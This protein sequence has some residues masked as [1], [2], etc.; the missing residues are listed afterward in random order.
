MT[1]TNKLT[2]ELAT[3]I[4]WLRTSAQAG[5]DTAGPFIAEQTPLYI[6]ELIQYT[7]VWTVFKAAMWLGLLIL[8]GVLMFIAHRIGRKVDGDNGELF[9]QALFPA[10]VAFLGLMPLCGTLSSIGVDEGIKYTAPRVFVVDKLTE[11]LP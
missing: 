5:A 8:V 3:T 10:V 6:E 9:L 11:L 2:E 4:E 1:A 7:I